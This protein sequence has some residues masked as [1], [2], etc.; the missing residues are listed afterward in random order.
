MSNVISLDK[1]K[2]NKEEII[3]LIIERAEEALICVLKLQVASEKLF[4]DELPIYQLR[5]MEKGITKLLMMAKKEK[6]TG[7]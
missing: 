1:K 5:N 6:I 7:E 2:K 3:N 4:A